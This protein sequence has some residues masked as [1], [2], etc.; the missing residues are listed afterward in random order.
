MI[1]LFFACRPE[2]DSPDYETSTNLSE[3]ALVTSSNLGPDPLQT[4]ESRLNLGLFYEGESTDEIIIDN[5]NTQFFI[6]SDSFSVNSISDSI[7]GD[8]ADELVVGTLGWWGGGVFSNTASDFSRYVTLCVSLK[9]DF[10][11]L[12]AVEVGIGEGDGVVLSW[13]AASDYGFQANGYW[14]NLRIPMSDLTATLDPTQINMLFN[15]RGEGLPEDTLLI[16]NLYL[17]TDPVDEVLDI[18]EEQ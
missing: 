9:S 7:E 13:A 18:Q 17:T 12:T 6:W 2:L 1:F 10:D 3:D 14:H 15:I 4:G 5:L 8:W 16:D 11:S